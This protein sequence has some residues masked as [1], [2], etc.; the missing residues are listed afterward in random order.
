MARV[1][2]ELLDEDAIVAEGGGRLVLRQREA[3]AALRVVPGDAHALAAAA[4]GGLDHHRIA[5]LVGDLDG[6]L[7][8][9]DHAEITRNRRDLGGVGE[10][11]RFDLVAHRLDGARVRTDEDDAVVLQRLTE[12]GALG[13]E[14][15][16]GMHRLGAGR[17]ARRDDLV[18]EEVGLRGLRGAEVDGLVGHLDVHRVTI[19]VG[20]DRD[21]LDTH[22]ARRLDDAAGDLAT[23]G[24]QDLLEHVV[25]PAPGKKSKTGVVL[26]A[27]GGL[28]NS[29]SPHRTQRAPRKRP[30]NPKT[31][32]VHGS[33]AA[34][35][36]PLSG[37][38]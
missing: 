5:D 38:S 31:L 34:R 37:T 8:V 11:L 9:L 7:G 1:D 20:I 21:G 15:V 23:V 33:A 2:D 17:L 24:D 29:E 12:G 13:Q 27:S 28:R 25:T 10:L 36:R 32:V 4:G 30:E 26:G 16:A 14:A 22:L 6:V 35:G 18:G 3:L 19:G